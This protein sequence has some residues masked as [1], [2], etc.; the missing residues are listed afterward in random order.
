MIVPSN[1]VFAVAWSSDDFV[2]KQFEEQQPPLI[3]HAA[4]F[5]AV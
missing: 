1:F 3:S 5:K 2:N 4:G